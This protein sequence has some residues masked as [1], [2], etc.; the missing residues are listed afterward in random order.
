MEKETLLRLFGKGTKTDRIN[1]ETFARWA[2]E[3][4]DIE[5]FFLMFELVPDPLLEREVIRAILN[6]QRDREKYINS[7]LLDAKQ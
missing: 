5:E 1:L 4:F 6:E 3:Y 2:K 7:L